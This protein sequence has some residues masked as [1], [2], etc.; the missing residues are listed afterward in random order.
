MQRLG[1]FESLAATT[2]KR[3]LR[4]QA[5]CTN[6]ASAQISRNLLQ[7]IAIESAI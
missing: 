6:Y 3:C 4:A 5:E 7:R 2:L 1:C